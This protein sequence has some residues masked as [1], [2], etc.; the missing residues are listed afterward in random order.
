MTHAVHVP[1]NM[2]SI[3]QSCNCREDTAWAYDVKSSSF[4][5]FGGWA[6]RWLGDLMRLNV[7]AIIGPP[8]AC[9]GV[10]CTRKL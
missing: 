7:S 8:Y 1:L 4:L 10:M 9:T 3:R 5:I 2:P 6:S